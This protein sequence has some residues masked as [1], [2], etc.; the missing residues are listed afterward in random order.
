[1]TQEEAIRQL[2]NQI[3]PNGQPASIKAIAMAVSALEKEKEPAPSANN[4]S[5]KTN[6][7][8][9]NDTTENR[10]CQEAFARE[11]QDEGI[12]SQDIKLATEIIKA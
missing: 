7:S 6:T 9:N 8:V 10:F 5:S 1:M 12:D 2:K 3:V 11:C 4:A